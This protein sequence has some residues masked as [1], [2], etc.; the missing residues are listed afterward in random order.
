MSTLVH[1]R[2]VEHLQRLR[3]GFVAERLDAVL[4]EAAKQEPTYL[5]F[6]DQVLRQEV[7]AKQRKRVAMGVQTFAAQAYG[8]GRY[9]RAGCAAW[10]G[11]WASLLML[12]AFLVLVALVIFGEYA[13]GQKLRVFQ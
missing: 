4:N 13:V 1:A 3:L 5:D 2:V 11:I 6:L 12:P 9:R 10:S 8:A 7:E